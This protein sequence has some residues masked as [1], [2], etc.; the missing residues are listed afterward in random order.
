MALAALFYLGN[1]GDG[2]GGSPRPGAYPYQVGAPGP[3]E[4]APPIRLASTSGETFDLSSLRGRTV[5]LYFQE[6]LMC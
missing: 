1:R 6:G 3:G 2:P 5:L 4:E